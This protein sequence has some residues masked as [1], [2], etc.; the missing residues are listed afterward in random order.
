MKSGSPDAGDFIWIDLDPTKDHEQ[1]GRRSALVLSPRLYNERT[2]LCVACPITNQARDIRSKFEVPIGPGQAVAGAVLCDQLG[3]LSWPERDLRI[4][5][6]APAEVVDE[7]RAK[8]AALIG[9]E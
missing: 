5:G 7:V 4:V 8:I 3:C 6:T 2:G 1:R 9:I